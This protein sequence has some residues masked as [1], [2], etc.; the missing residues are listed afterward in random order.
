MKQVIYDISPDSL[1]ATQAFAT[2]R[3]DPPP[4]VKATFSEQY[5]LIGCA[6][7]VVLASLL[8]GVNT[9]FFHWVGNNYFPEDTLLIGVILLLMLLGARLQW[10]STHVSYAIVRELFLFYLVLAS[11]AL[12]TNAVQYTPFTPI[13]GLI[14]Q[15]ESYLNINMLD[16]MIWANQHPWLNKALLVAYASLDYQMVLLPLFCL[17]SLNWQRLHAYYFLLLVSALLGFTIY[18]F[19]PTTAPA[20][21]LYSTLFT[22]EQHATGMKFYEIHH[23]LTPSTHLGGLIAFPSFHVI[24]GWFCIYLAYPYRALFILALPLNCLLFCACVLLGWHYPMD[25]I[26]SALIILVSHFLQGRLLL[27]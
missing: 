10:H 11:I 19:F 24:W 13:D 18:Y 16:L 1:E 6:V 14:I 17:V 25:V 3:L 20:S 26:G 21:N 9:V 23:H 27:K 4:T 15:A 8:L 2:P 12:L 5:I 7:S 22:N